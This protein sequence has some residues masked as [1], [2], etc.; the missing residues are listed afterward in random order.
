[1]TNKRGKELRDYSTDEYLNRP[2]KPQTHKAIK[3]AYDATYKPT[4]DVNDIKMMGKG[5]NPD[6]A[7]SNPVMKDLVSRIVNLENE[8]DSNTEVY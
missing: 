8:R 6:Q 3:D 2:I 7:R 5:I 4:A 1:M